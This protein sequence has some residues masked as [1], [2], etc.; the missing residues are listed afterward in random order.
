MPEVVLVDDDD[1]VSPALVLNKL[2]A[3]APKL[4]EPKS[5]DVAGTLL[6]LL[7]CCSGCEFDMIFVG[8]PNRVD[9]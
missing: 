2:F 5:F 3:P 7:F 9:D 4:R 1:S 8:A 6:V